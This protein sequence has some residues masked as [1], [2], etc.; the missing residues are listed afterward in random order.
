MRQ[1][2]FHQW[3]GISFVH[4]LIAPLLG[5]YL[6]TYPLSRWSFY[7]VATALWFLLFSLILCF[8]TVYLLS[9]YFH[10]LARLVMQF[11][12]RVFRA[13]YAL[14]RVTT[15]LIVLMGAIRLPPAALPD[16]AFFRLAD[17]FGFWLFQSIAIAQ[18]LHHFFYKFTSGSRLRSDGLLDQIGKGKPIDWKSPIGGSIG[19]ELRRMRRIEFRQ[20][21]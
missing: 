1:Y 13:I 8:W 4:W 15:L 21:T 19:L 12:L 17:D 2:F 9:Y 5:I 3:V 16:E 18:G 10:P 6:A 7:Q 20:R 11:R 14:G